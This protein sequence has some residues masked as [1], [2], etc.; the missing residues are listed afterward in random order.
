MSDKIGIF[1]ECNKLKS[2]SEF[3]NININNNSAE[4]EKIKKWNWKYT[5]IPNPQSPHIKNN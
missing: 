2:L 5:P 1:D 3:N 4:I